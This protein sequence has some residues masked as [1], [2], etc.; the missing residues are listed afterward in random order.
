MDFEYWRKIT[1]TNEKKIQGLKNKFVLVDNFV[2][3]EKVDWR[4]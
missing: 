3:V 2:T 4:R 1:A